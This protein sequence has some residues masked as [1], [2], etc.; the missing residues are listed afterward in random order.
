[1]NPDRNF[2]WRTLLSSVSAPFIH[3]CYA[4][5]SP[6][7]QVTDFPCRSCAR[8]GYDGRYWAHAVYHLR[9]TVFGGSDGLLP[10]WEYV[11][12]NIPTVMVVLFRCTNTRFHVISGCN[13]LEI[14]KPQLTLDLL[15]R[16]VSARRNRIIGRRGARSSQLPDVSGQL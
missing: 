16:R 4:P 8:G 3:Q 5:S 1:M 6:C 7:H 9:S 10:F 12:P 14:N 13:V 11:G 15:F 2:R